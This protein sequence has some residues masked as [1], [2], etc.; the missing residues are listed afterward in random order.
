MEISY[1]RAK[2]ERTLIERGLDFEAARNVFAGL[3]ITQEDE[4][5]EY[6][7]RRFQTY[8][9]LYDRMVV[10]VWTETEDGRRI[11]SMRKCNDREQTRYRE[12][13]G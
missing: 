5:F 7:E 12:Q 4:R 8:G 2:R 13:L 6:D 3:Q 10:V 9:L 11:I 1:D